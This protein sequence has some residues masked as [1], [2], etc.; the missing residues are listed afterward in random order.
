[1]GPGRR[2]PSEGMCF[3]QR[4]QLHHS[5]NRRMYVPYFGD[6]MEINKSLKF[7]LVFLKALQHPVP[8]GPAGRFSEGGGVEVLGPEADLKQTRSPG[9][10]FHFFILTSSHH[11]FDC[12][13]PKLPSSPS[14]LQVSQSPLLP[15]PRPHPDLEKCVKP[16]Q[17]SHLLQTGS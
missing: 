10:V 13:C 8:A 7:Q 14:V 3:Q 5:P 2:K 9:P 4:S 11:E 17:F 6:P 12:G 15:S 1:M 16:W